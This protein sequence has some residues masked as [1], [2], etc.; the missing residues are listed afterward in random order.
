MDVP[1]IALWQREYTQPHPS[2]TVNYC[3]KGKTMH[4]GLPILR[5]IIR[6]A[7]LAAVLS[8]TVAAADK[9]LPDPATGIEKSPTSAKRTAV[10]AGGCFWCTEAVFEEIAGVDKVVSGYAGGTAQTAKYDIVSA[11]KTDHA[12][13]IEVTFDPSKVSYGQL[14]K[15]FFGAAHDPTQLNRQGPDWGRQYRSEIFYTDAE[16]KRVAEA[17]IKQLQA[18]KVFGQPI[19]TEVAALEKFYPAEGYHQD[20]VKR[21]PTHRYVVVNALP[22]IEKV[23]REFPELV[24]KSKS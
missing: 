12:E 16:Q 17:Y 4:I 18:A 1:I 15:V 3:R 9:S 22:K 11:G 19:V 7:G 5:R 10:F 13:S 23:R 20:F 8:F 21:N 6:A 14:L 24:K 2:Y